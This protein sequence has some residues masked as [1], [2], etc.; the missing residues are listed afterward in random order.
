MI[1]KLH[2]TPHAWTHDFNG[3]LHDKICLWYELMFFMDFKIRNY[4]YDKKASKP[5][6]DKLSMWLFSQDKDS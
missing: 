2:Y 6:Y 1:F 4:V 3:F 5:N